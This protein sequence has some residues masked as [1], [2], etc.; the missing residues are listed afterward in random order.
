MT[1]PENTPAP[2]EPDDEERF[3]QK[4]AALLEIAQEN[5]AKDDDD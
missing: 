3:E 2:I 1:E 4:A 5:R